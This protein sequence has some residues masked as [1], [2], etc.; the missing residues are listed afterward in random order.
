[1][2]DGRPRSRFRSVVRVG[3]RGEGEGEEVVEEEGEGDERVIS[4]HFLDTIS[5]A[6]S[7]AISAL[8]TDLTNQFLPEISLY[9]LP[10]IKRPSRLPSI[11]SPISYG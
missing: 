11:N 9:T 4:W 5:F 7:A 6:H 2:V 8:T 3:L 10:N 1:M